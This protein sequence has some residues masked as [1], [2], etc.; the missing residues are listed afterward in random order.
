MA[1]DDP[2]MADPPPAPL[3]YSTPVISMSI[4]DNGFVGH[5]IP[6]SAQGALKV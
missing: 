4:P 6:S 1:A 2:G 5:D 3:S